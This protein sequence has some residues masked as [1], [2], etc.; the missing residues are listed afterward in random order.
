MPDLREFIDQ[1][2]AADLVQILVTLPLAM[3]LLIGTRTLLRR[4]D[5]GKGASVRTQAVMAALTLVA[6]VALVLALPIEGD[7]KHDLLNL[8]AVLGSA[9]IALSSTTLLGNILAGMMLRS[10]R[11]FRM[12]DFVRCGDHFGRVT[13]RGLVHTEIQTED[14]DLTTLPNLF[15]IQNPVTV[16]RASGTILSTEVSLGYDVA[17]ADVEPALH[18]AA[19]AAELEEPFVQV[20]KLGD[21]SVTYRVA[22][23]LQDVRQLISR[24]SRLNGEVIDHLHRA[25]IEIVSPTFM[26]TRA[27]TPETK[28]APTASARSRGMAAEGSNVEDLA[29]DKADLAQSLG[30]LVKAEQEIQE[31]RAKLTA[32]VK[33]AQD[34]PERER[35]KGAIADADRRLERLAKVIELR[36]EHLEADD[37]EQAAP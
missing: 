32:E 24:R 15:L 8:L 18:A 35:L 12:G 26:N 20:L 3:L 6:V 2:Q 1:L 7:A 30:Q 27:F 22:G 37:D 13:E 28:V 29:F 11:N 25:G 9:A 14:R 23:M 19:R 21:F 17:R 31:E 4:G 34:A 10:V 36:Q 16:V 5:G 33:A